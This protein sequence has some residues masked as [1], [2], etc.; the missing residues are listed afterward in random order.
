MC[1][2]AQ[3]PWILSH[4]ANILPERGSEPSWHAMQLVIIFDSPLADESILSLL[5]LQFC[6][7][8]VSWYSTG[9]LLIWWSCTMSPDSDLSQS[10]QEIS[11]DLAA[12]NQQRQ[13][14]K[15]VAGV[16]VHCY[17]AYIFFIPVYFF[18]VLIY[19]RHYNGIKSGEISAVLWLTLI[20]M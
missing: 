2:H 7:H 9:L 14:T 3:W 11:G 17:V 15:H 6:L 4:Q 20:F 16:S 13:W 19:E 10:Q 12:R 5:S 18:S 1:C 8:C